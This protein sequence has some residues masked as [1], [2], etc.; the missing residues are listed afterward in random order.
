MEKAIQVNRKYVHLGY[1]NTAEQA[2]KAYDKAA[3]ENFG[4]FARTNF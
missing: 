3:I 4:E 2:A 1:F